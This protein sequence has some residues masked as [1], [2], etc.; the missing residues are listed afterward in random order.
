[1][2]IGID[3]LELVAR[4]L[5]DHLR[6][7]GIEEV[8]VEQ[9]FYWNI[10]KAQRYNPNETPNELTL[11]QLSDDWQEL[12]RMLNGER[13]AIGYALVWLSAI[14]RCVGEEVT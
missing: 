12:Q 6:D 1:M 5:F 11:G 10:S 13:D 8:S 7:K 14:L 9:D 3:E 2:R 4:Q